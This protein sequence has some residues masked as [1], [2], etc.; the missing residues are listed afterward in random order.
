MALR[1]R[2]KGSPA[3]ADTT[4]AA[5][6]KQDGPGV[7]SSPLIP[8]K[9][10]ALVLLC[11]QNASVSIL[12]RQSR[13]TSSRSLYNPSVAVFT[14]ELI[15]AALSISML[16]VERRKVS[17][18]K[19]GSGGYLWHAG[20]AV[21]DLARNQRT[22]VVKL[23]VPAML[24]ALQNTLLYV[25]L[26]NLD[27]ATYQTT[28]QL[29]LLTTA[30]FSILFFRRSLSVQKWISLILLTTGVAIVQLES[31]EPKPSPTRHVSLSQDPTKGFAAILAAC[32]SSGLA[33][34]WFEWVLKSPS[35]SAPT[36]A[37]TPD[38]P[39]SPSLQLRKNSPSLWARNLQLSVPSLL[40]SFS[41]VLLSSPIRNAFE[42]RGLE[43][44]VRALGGMWTGFTPL[45]WCVVLNQALGGL[46]VAMVVRE[47]DSVAKGF[48]TSIA[49][50]LS[51]L[52]SAVLF[53]VVPGTMLIVGGLLVISST[54]L[55][56]LDKD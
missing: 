38:S 33:G 10:L 32:L 28:Y 14:A 11:V 45:V 27:A 55:Y 53:G 21:Q 56:S 30:I 29:K 39:K 15:K 48:A 49:I 24:Y 26:S 9:T 13:T 18:A 20:A 35:S 51:T 5:Q 3:P 34:A 2:R 4:H 7:A 6:T 17:R 31:S 12:T 37:A 54:V 42:K 19:A 1:Q 8:R 47:A 52:A 25:A 16:A 23:A 46:L 43:E 41:G 44:A 36:P 40:F 50:V 22:E